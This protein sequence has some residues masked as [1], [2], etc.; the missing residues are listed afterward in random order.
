MICVRFRRSGR[1]PDYPRLGGMIAR[2][3]LV[4]E[5]GHGRTAEIQ[6]EILWWCEAA[7]VPVIWTTQVPESI[8]KHGIGSRMEF[9]DA[10][11]GVRAECVMLNKGPCILD[12]L[13]SLN[14]VLKCM[15]A[16][17]PKII[18]RLRLLHW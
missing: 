5:L 2:G 18:S 6:K 4:I 16:H 11:M 17:Q 8:A 14:A 12:A 9:I 15:Q 10:A 7:H 3:D 13:R 1:R